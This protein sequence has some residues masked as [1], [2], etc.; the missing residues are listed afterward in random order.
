[1][2]LQVNPHNGRYY[3]CIVLIDLFQYSNSYALVGGNLSLA[4]TAAS[5]A[6]ED[7]L[8]QSMECAN[9]VSTTSTLVPPLTLLRLYARLAPGLSVSDWMDDNNVHLLGLDA[10]RMMS[11]GVIKGFLRRCHTYPVWLDHPAFASSKVQP[12]RSR[13]TSSKRSGDALGPAPDHPPDLPRWL[14]GT[15]HTDELCLE[16][17]TNVATL[18]GW[19]AVVGQAGATAR[20][21]PLGRVQLLVL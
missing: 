13:S 1:V 9:Y 4:A 5:D 14:D 19:L 6:P 16:F 10:R 15:H 7:G 21:G 20:D 3:S 18:K 12:V 2:P 8:P 17:K 11:F